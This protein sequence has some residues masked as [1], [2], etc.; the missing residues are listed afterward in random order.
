M[1]GGRP[2]VPWKNML[3]SLFI[4]FTCLAWLTWPNGLAPKNGG[5]RRLSGDTQESHG[6]EVGDDGHPGEPPGHGDGHGDG[7]GGAAHSG[8]HASGHAHHEASLTEIGASLALI[9][10]VVTLLI[11]YMFVSCD[12][13][14]IAAYSW[15]LFSKGTTI[16]VSV[17]IFMAFHQ[18]W[19][20]LVGHG[21]RTWLALV[22]GLVCLGLVCV[23]SSYLLL[24][25]SRGTANVAGIS[26]RKRRFRGVD[27]KQISRRDVIGRTFGTILAHTMAFT[28]I[29]FWSNV[30]QSLHDQYS[31][32]G[33]CVFF[34]A[35]VIPAACALLFFLVAITARLRYHYTKM[36]DKIDDDE[37]AWL[38]KCKKIDIDA[39]AM[40]VAFITVQ[41][42]RY[43]VTGRMP[44]VFG[45]GLTS[46]ETH[47]K[48]VCFTFFTFALAA[49]VLELLLNKLLHR[50]RGKHGE[51]GGGC[52]SVLLDVLEFLV[53]YV[54]YLTGWSLLLGIASSV[55]FLQGQHVMLH[56]TLI[57][58]VCSLITFATVFF[59]DK[60]IDSLHKTEWNIK[61]EG[62]NIIQVVSLM[63]GL[64]WER[65]FHHANEVLAEG[66][67]TV[68]PS[69]KRAPY[70]WKANL[71]A[72]FD[73]L[74]VILTTLAMFWH[75]NPRLLEARAYA[76]YCKDRDRDSELEDESSSSDEGSCHSLHLLEVKGEI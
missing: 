46:E 59:L 23:L 32:Q 50:C 21:N 3:S 54:S 56:R 22:M 2:C 15:N 53:V 75:I 55:L 67:S 49:V 10:G 17:N 12:D 20:G 65:C 28:M 61:V 40:E 25:A 73:L 37:Q 60:I 52:T 8:P 29:A 18:V 76:R 48:W 1:R 47:R 62:E 7:H 14:D 6:P 31:G 19:V 35:L 33:S 30:Q 4:G 44:G 41:V 13:A 26:V 27:Y 43:T 72:V 74:I 39:G 24:W 71:P 70:F 68:M 45:N 69:L 42:L 16:F 38:D 63:M 51:G 34:I 58:V 36:D 64:T 9:S 57:A 5:W 66:A 11:L